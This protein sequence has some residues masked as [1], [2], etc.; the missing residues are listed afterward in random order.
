MKSKSSETIYRPLEDPCVANEIKKMIEQLWKPAK[1]GIG[2]DA[3]GL[4]HSSI[5]IV[6]IKLIGNKEVFHSYSQRKRMIQKFASTIGG[7]LIPPEKYSAEIGP[8]QTAKLLKS[9]PFL[10]RNLN[11]DI[12]EHYLF[13]GTPVPNIP[14]IQKYGFFMEKYKHSMLGKGIYF[15]EDP[16]KADQYT[17]ISFIFVSVGFYVFTSHQ[18]S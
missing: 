6:D 12:N 17:G 2:R 10:V 11:N 16:V 13:H 5:K 3:K 14:S 1:V 8:I 9:V 15:T 18:N 7:K 4:Y